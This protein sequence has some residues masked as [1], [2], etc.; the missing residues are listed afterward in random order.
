MEIP[1]KTM[2]GALDASVAVIVERDHPI[3]YWPWGSTAAGL[4]IL[5]KSHQSRVGVVGLM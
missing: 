5:P 2:Q 3:Q 1:S 4:D